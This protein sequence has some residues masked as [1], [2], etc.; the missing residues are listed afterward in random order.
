M[1]ISIWTLTENAIAAYQVLPLSMVGITK[2]GFL[3]LKQILIRWRFQF[4]RLALQ[5]KFL[6]IKVREQSGSK[7]WLVLPKILFALFCLQLADWNQIQDILG[8]V[9]LKIEKSTRFDFICH[10]DFL[11]PKEDLEDLKFNHCLISSVLIA[12]VKAFQVL[13]GVIL[14]LEIDRF[15]ACLLEML[16][17][18]I[19]KENE[20]LNLEASSIRELWPQAIVF[21]R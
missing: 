3:S 8:S 17:L 13:V 12:I 19:D 9:Y 18:V 15:P 21:V 20:Q 16:H 5:A 10:S 1:P 11:S 14:P 7:S 6:A 4:L 2:W